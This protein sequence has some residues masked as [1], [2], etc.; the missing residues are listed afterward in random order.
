MRQ[1]IAG[2]VLGA[3]LA[4][5]GQHFFEGSDGDDQYADL[6]TR[7]QAEEGYRA[8]PYR[9]T[10][11]VL[12]VGFGTN[13]SEG[14]TRPEATYLLRSRLD[15]NGECLA[16]KWKPWQLAGPRAREVL[17]DMTYE[18]GCDGVAGDPRV[19]ESGDC[20]K[21]RTERPAGCGF[22]DMLAALA[23]RDFKAAAREMMNSRYARQVPHRAASLQ[24]LLLAR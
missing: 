9:D 5:G 10:R 19:I 4:L 18:L 22:H 16:E 20:D 23:D 6:V 17:L 13:L 14:L 8:T 7:L 2:A 11:G 15:R 1:H 21:P 24:A 12:T 3:T